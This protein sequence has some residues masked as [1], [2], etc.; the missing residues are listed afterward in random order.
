[1]Q[2]ALKQVESV[3]WI[4]RKY[5]GNSAPVRL[6]GL[7]LKWVCDIGKKQLSTPSVLC[8]GVF[9]YLRTK[10]SISKEKWRNKKKKKSLF[11]VAPHDK[12]HSPHPNCF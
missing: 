8:R 11:P 1:M 2:G 4:K 10:L 6:Q 3:W 9:L 7:A 12:F 5:S